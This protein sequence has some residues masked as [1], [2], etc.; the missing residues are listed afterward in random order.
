MKFGNPCREFV[1]D[2]QDEQGK[3]GMKFGR[4]FKKTHGTMSKRN[5]LQS[6]FV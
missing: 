3:I 5:A 4:S 2:G 6:E 1:V